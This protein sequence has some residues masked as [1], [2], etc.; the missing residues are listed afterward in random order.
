MEWMLLDIAVNEVNM[1]NGKLVAN[2]L[3]EDKWSFKYGVVF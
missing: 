3:G 1:P 2:N